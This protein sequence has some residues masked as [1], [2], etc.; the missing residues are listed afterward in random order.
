MTS[1]DIC[2]IRFVSDPQLSPDSRRVAFVV[3]TLSE[4]R[5]EYLS[6]LWIVDTMGGPCRRFTH[7][8]RRDTA[9]RWS[10]DG[11]QL[12][13]LSE[14]DVTRGGKPRPQLYVMAADGGEAVRLTD[15]PLGVQP[16]VWSPDGTRLVF[17]ARVGPKDGAAGDGPAGRAG[18]EAEGGPSPSRP[19]RVITTLKYR[20][21]GEGF[22]YD[23]RPHLFVVSATGGDPRQLT[24]GDFA[25]EHPAWSPDGR[26]VAFVSARHADRDHD[27]AADVFVVSAEGG[28]PRRV[29]ATA[30]PAAHPVF[31]PDG[32]AIAYL[33][34]PHPTD[35]SRN[36]RL[37]TVAVAGGPATCLTA[38]L[39]RTCQPFFATQGPVWSS[40][41][42]IRFAVEDRGDV[43]IYRVAGDGSDAG[44]GHGA[45]EPIVGGERLVTGLSVSPDGGRVAFTAT[46]PVA[47]AEVFVCGGDGRDERR[48]TDL[49]GAWRQEVALSR[50]ER[51]RVDRAGFTVDGWVMRPPSFEPGRR[52]PVL[53]NVHGGPA[54]QYGHGFFDEFQ[55]YAGAGYAVVYTNPRG[56]QGYGE[57]FARAVVGDWGGGDVADVMAGLDAALAR[58]DFLDP[59]RLGVMGGSYGGFVTSWIVGHSDRFRAA[60]SERALNTHV[61]MIGTS[62]IGHYFVE[63]HAGGVPPLWEDP[64]WYVEHSPLTYA[65][66]IRTPLLIVHSEDDLRCP[67]EQAEQLFVALKRLRREV[68]LVR[69]PDENHD[70]SR[71]GRPRHRLERFRII[72]DWFGRHLGAPAG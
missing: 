44:A 60:C 68:V 3:T 49:N 28:E 24:D 34:H 22:V 59:A 11:R 12:A 31:S 33:G 43:P 65:A 32:R 16:P 9:P 46:D 5:D 52:Y 47:P 63:A 57:A 72:L 70:L 42:F 38:G 17:A 21:N 69:F 48:L 8:P 41:G 14:R 29:T 30:G 20:W 51:F 19:A 37:Y 55:V 67:M 7:G 13:F 58:Y 35:V 10:P 25:D 53:L 27:L 66:R 45:P 15:L 40:D 64:R 54:T 71:T 62:D 1:A 18:A 36:M 6:A 2:R 56:S 26:L 61:S 39:D 23:R 50:P 4:E